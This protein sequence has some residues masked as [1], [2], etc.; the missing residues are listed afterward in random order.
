MAQK[1]D[2]SLHNKDEE[3]SRRRRARRSGLTNTVGPSPAVVT[4]IHRAVLRLTADRSRPDDLPA[5]SAAA[6]TSARGFADRTATPLAERSVP[7]AVRGRFVRVGRDFHFLSGAHAFRDHGRKLVTQT[8]N[9]AVIRALVDIA[10]DRGWNDITITGTERF[11]SDAWRIATV[12]GLIVRGYRPTEFEKQKLVR[13]LAVARQR[14]RR[15]E[16]LIDS[17]QRQALP[18]SPSTPPLAA[19]QTNPRGGE[20]TFAGTLLEHGPAPYE[21]HPHGDPSYF[22]QIKTRRGPIVLWGKD[23]ERAVHDAHVATGEE[24]QV[25][26]AGRHTVTVK[27]KEHDHEGRVVGE[28]D[29]KAHRNQWEVSRDQHGAE[30]RNPRTKSRPA[31][32]GDR[33]WPGTDSALR[34]LKGAQLFA[35]ER[36]GD[37]AQRSAFVNAVREQLVAALER[38]DAPPAAR[39]RGTPRERPAMSARTLS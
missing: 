32:H 31:R 7:D 5:K 26:Q 15:P 9:T 6:Q 12:S 1:D 34:A 27:R 13:D 30:Q 4:W 10:V 33:E 2:A 37:P 14:S 28:H 21:F 25:R 24:V 23:L 16:P 39:L 38:G 36:I 29:I 8:E 3:S 17:P 11:R 35:K 18:N 22:V 20:R 19:T